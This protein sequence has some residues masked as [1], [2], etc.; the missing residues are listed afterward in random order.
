M[1]SL[2]KRALPTIGANVETSA[3]ASS[4]A[5]GRPRFW[6]SFAELQNR[7]EFRALLEREFAA[8]PPEGPADAPER[9]RFLQLMGA[10]LG[11]AGVGCTWHEDKL[12]PLSRRPEET[13]PGT[14]KKFAT[15]ME[16]DGVAVGLRATSYDGRPIKIDGNP[17]HPE[18]LGGSNSLH[19]ASVLG[20]YDPDRSDKPWKRGAGAASASSWE[21]FAE[22][23]KEHF[24]KLKG[25]GYNLRVLAER[26]SSP[27]LAALKK[28][29]L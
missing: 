23:A 21:A 7:P 1:S 22:F 12:L 6:R 29:F 28:R 27:T 24:G 20:V 18:S 4:H 10:S 9:R 2:K 8:P 16:L 5:S 13:V 11:L 26:S 25:K 14:T 19:Q 15:A 3:P 17:L